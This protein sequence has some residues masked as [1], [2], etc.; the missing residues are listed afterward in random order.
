MLSLLQLSSRPVVSVPRGSRI[1][2]ASAR[3]ARCWGWTI[4]PPTPTMVIPSRARSSSRLRNYSRLAPSGAAIMN[5]KDRFAALPY[6]NHAILAPF[7][8]MGSPSLMMLPPV[9]GAP[10]TLK[11]YCN[12][13]RSPMCARFRAN[14]TSLLVAP[15]RLRTR[16]SSAR[17]EPLPGMISPRMQMRGI[18]GLARSSSRCIQLLT[19][20]LSCARWEKLRSIIAAPPPLHLRILVPPLVKYSCKVGL[21]AK[22]S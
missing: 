8:P 16:A 18:P 3:T 7:A 2:A 4:S 14:T 1:P 19:P 11:G 15:S 5:I 21:L 6:L 10:N 20:D 17:M 13:N 9:S 22:Y 12:S